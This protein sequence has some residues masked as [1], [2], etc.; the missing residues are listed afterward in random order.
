MPQKNN[1]SPPVVGYFSTIA[2]ILGYGDRKYA[3]IEQSDLAKQFILIQF[4]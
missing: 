4:S 2:G 1:H 3:Q